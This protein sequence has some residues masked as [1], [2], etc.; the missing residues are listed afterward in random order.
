MSAVKPYCRL[1]LARGSIL[2]T[3]FLYES[4][5]RPA[6]AT[7]TERHITILWSVNPRGKLLEIARINWLGDS[8]SKNRSTV[9]V[10]GQIM[11]VDNILQTSRSFFRS[12]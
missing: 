6:F 10:N 4:P 9:L 1:I 8:S 2:D 3:L 5:R 11:L 12:E 7:T